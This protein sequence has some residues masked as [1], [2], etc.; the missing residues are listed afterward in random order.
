M[1]VVMMDGEPVAEPEASGGDI[2][3]QDYGKDESMVSKLWQP[4]VK[5]KNLPKEQDLAIT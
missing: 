2:I 3:P 1:T 5:A 4:G